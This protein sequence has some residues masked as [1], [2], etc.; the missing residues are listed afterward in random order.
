[1]KTSSTHFNCFQSFFLSR[2]TGKPTEKGWAV[3]VTF[4]A[5]GAIG[6]LVA[7]LAL[8]S[9]GSHLPKALSF[10]SPLGTVRFPGSIALCTA[11]GAALLGGIVLAIILKRKAPSQN[12]EAQSQIRFSATSAKPSP[13]PPYNTLPEVASEDTLEYSSVLEESEFLAVKQWIILPI[14]LSERHKVTIDEKNFETTFNG[15]QQQKLRSVSFDVIQQRNESIKDQLITVALKLQPGEV[16]HSKLG[17]RLII[18]LPTQSLTTSPFD[19]EEVYYECVK[20]D[21]AKTSYAFTS[22]RFKLVDQATLSAR[23]PYQS[24]AKNFEKIP[25]AD[26]D[27]TISSFLDENEFFVAQKNSQIVFFES[28]KKTTCE[29]I[30]NPDQF[31]QQLKNFTDRGLTQVTVQ[32]LFDKRRRDD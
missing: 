3:A 31:D 12:T 27:D 9:L 4:I 18:K 1:M 13:C 23:P 10:F 19:S 28:D 21:K 16:Y 2:Q 11:G 26:G 14:N 7:T 25:L 6:T 29:T 5:L 8:L 15:Y 24:T 22:G 17:N 32:A 30:V 20:S